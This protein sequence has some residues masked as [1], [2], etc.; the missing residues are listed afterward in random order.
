MKIRWA[1][2]GK[3]VDVAPKES[4]GPTTPP[5][6]INT[7]QRTPA[8]IGPR[9]VQ[10]RSLP[11]AGQSGG[12]QAGFVVG[13]AAVTQSPWQYGNERVGL[14]RLFRAGNSGYSSPNADGYPMTGDNSIVLKRPLVRLPTRGSRSIAGAMNP[15][16][17][18]DNQGKAPVVFGPTVPLR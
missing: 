9:P 10:R 2:W 15:K 16:S 13:P 6:R 12:Q 17:T 11:A 5:P 7:G 18:F 1:A 8:Q 3:P 4:I 14:L